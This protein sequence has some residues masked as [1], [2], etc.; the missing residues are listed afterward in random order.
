MKNK[1]IDGN[2]TFST[3]LKILGENIQKIRIE[4]NITLKD[5]SERT[6]IRERYL[7]KIEKDTAARITAAH[8]YKIADTLEVEAYLL[9]YE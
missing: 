2:N 3:T 1:I 8:L 9:L 4:K 5:L 7:K 6:G